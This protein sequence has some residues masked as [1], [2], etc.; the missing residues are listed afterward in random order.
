MHCELRRTGATPISHATKTL[1]RRTSHYYTFA[2]AARLVTRS[3]RDNYNLKQHKY[4]CI[5][6]YQPDTKSGGAENDGHENDGPIAGH[7]NAGHEIARHDK[8]LF[9][10][11]STNHSN[12]SSIVENLM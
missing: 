7:E 3:V 5:T 10:V 4:V 11:V 8:Y 12:F 1:P 6:T 9:I 2:A